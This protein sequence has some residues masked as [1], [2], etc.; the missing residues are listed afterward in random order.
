MRMHCKINVFELKILHQAYHPIKNSQQRLLE[1][2]FDKS[3]VSGALLLELLKK[4]HISFPSMKEC[5]EDVTRK[6]N[7]LH[8]SI[9]GVGKL[10]LVGKISDDLKPSK[11]AMLLIEKDD[12]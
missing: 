10:N 8:F 6:A 9:L 4:L 12:D 5:Q 7:Y 11:S 3:V 1:F 2:R